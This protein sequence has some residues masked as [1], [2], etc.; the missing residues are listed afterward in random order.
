MRVARFELVLLA[1]LGGSAGCGDNDLYPIRKPAD[2]DAG[3]IPGRPGTINVFD[4]IPQFRLYDMKDPANYTPPAGIAMWSYGTEYAAKLS[5]EQKRTIGGDLAARVTYHA[6]CDEVT[7]LGNVFAVIAPLGQTPSRDDPRIE[8]AR[9]VT[10]F[11]DF[12]RGPLATYTFPLADVSSFASLLAHPSH[13]TWIGLSGGSNPRSDDACAGASQTPEFRAIGFKYSLD[14]VSTTP[15]VRTASIAVVGLY[16]YPATSIPI[17]GTLVHSGSSAVQ[18]RVFATVT[19][20]GSGGAGSVDAQFTDDTVTLN[21]A[22]IG[23]FNTKI[24]CASYAQYSPDGNPALFLSTNPR[25]WCPG[26]LAPSHGFPATLLP[27]G[28]AVSLT[29]V[30]SAVPSGSTYPTS[31]VFVSP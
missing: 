4:Q 31:I 16:S 11:S 13:D 9:F 3:E 20:H 23:T 21:G 18:G 28:N 14:L 27:G 19:G 12:S 1:L 17:A 7:R 8:L 6:Q 22:E 30:P 26:A 25:N 29:V 10:P 5:P 24:D 2:A 15:L